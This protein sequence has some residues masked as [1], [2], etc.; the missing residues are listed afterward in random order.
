MPNYISKSKRMRV[1][2]T[3]A[4][5]IRFLK[6]VKVSRW[7]DCWVWKAHTDENGYAQFWFR[8]QAVWAHRWAYAVWRATVP[9]ERDIDHLCKNT[10]CVNPWHLRCTTTKTNRA[11]KEP[12]QF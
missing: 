4:E 11:T 2:A 6:H 1:R 10:S 5:I 3:P 9:A 8:K 12:A 7:N